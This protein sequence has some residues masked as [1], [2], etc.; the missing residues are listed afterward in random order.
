MRAILVLLAVSLVGTGCGKKANRT[1]SADESAMAL[2][3]EKIL[4]EEGLVLV[5]I[6]IDR[7]ERADIF[8]YYRERADA[9]RLLVKKEVDLNYDGQVDVIS[10]FEGDSLNREEMDGDFDGRFDTTDYYQDGRRVMTERDTNFDG[11]PDVFTNYTQGPDGTEIPTDQQRDSNGDGAIDE[12][13]RFDEQGNVTKTES[14]KNGEQI[15]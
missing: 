13:L 6:D 3:K 4:A 1:S 10:Y 2:V 8:N 11:K 12:W 9:P 15:K 7:D 5:E 14:Y